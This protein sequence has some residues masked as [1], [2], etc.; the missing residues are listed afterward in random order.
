VIL[1]KAFAKA[2]GSYSV[3]ISGTPHTSFHMLTNN[4]GQH[5]GLDE[6]ENKEK[7]ANGT[8]WGFLLEFHENKGVLCCSTRT[9]N[10]EGEGLV[11]HHAYAIL[12]VKILGKRHKLLC[13]RNPWG[14]KEWNGAWSD[15][16]KEWTEEYKKEVSH[17][18]KD[19]GLFWMSF[20]DFTKY[21]DCI[22]CSD[23]CIGWF[24]WEMKG[25]VGPKGIDV[26]DREQYLV[27]WP[28]KKK[29][30]TFR[31]TLE[32][33][34]VGGMLARCQCQDGG[35]VKGI[36]V[37]MPLLKSMQTPANGT[38]GGGIVDV[39]ESLEK[40]WTMVIESFAD[41]DLKYVLTIWCQED[42]GI[43]LTKIP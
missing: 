31:W 2:A 9:C 36:Y 38:F 16:S 26:A 4:W 33:D 21:Y 30:V 13:L 35:R 8:L 24:R 22:Y 37:G 3:I 39:T 18:E 14:Y 15:D 23:Q 10:M 6:E 12:K 34:K 5:I 20:E 19:D 17:V 25:T 40:V 1:E 28:E 29:K 7:I 27:R 11:G 41:V 32:T 43:S 42:I